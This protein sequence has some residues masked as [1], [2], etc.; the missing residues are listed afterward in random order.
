MT[1]DKTNGRQRRDETENRDS[2][3][4]RRPAFFAVADHR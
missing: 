1:I 4:P 3:E 2:M